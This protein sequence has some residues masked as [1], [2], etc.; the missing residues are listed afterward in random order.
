VYDWFSQGAAAEHEFTAE[1]AAATMAQQPLMTLSRFNAFVNRCRISCDRVSAADVE[2]IFSTVVNSSLRGMR[3]FSKRMAFDDFRDS[4]IE[5]AL[6]RYPECKA[7]TETQA[8]T[9]FE[10]GESQG[11]DGATAGAGADPAL[12]RLHSR[13]VLPLYEKLLA[14]QPGSRDAAVMHIMEEISQPAVVSFFGTQQ[15]AL[16][17]IFRRY[18]SMYGDVRANAAAK[19][20]GY[21]ALLDGA[22]FGAFARE[23]G[24][25]PHL[26]SEEELGAGFEDLINARSSCAYVLR[27]P[28]RPPARR[29]RCWHSC[30]PPTPPPSHPAN[31]PQ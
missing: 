9:A 8:R 14:V 4:L 3:K 12:L 5:L 20:M 28:P 17:K 25:T 19:E 10:A 15:A 24:I 13:H 21:G 31:V 7:E 16:R 1:T 18:S 30:C 11:G 29:C 6:K 27:A 26:I 2:T 23:K 22:A